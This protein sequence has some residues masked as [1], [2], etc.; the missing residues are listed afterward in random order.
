MREARLS[1]FDAE[2]VA[3]RGV[4]GNRHFLIH[5]FS[6]VAAASAAAAGGGGAAAGVAA[7]TLSDRRLTYYQ[8]FREHREARIATLS[9][10]GALIACSGR[11]Y[12]F[13][14]IE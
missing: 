2:S 14:R 5:Q 12:R 3:L 9:N 6:A 13:Q 7:R 10:A 1:M 8:V 4:C 11:S